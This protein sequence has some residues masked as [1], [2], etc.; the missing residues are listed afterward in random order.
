MNR[1]GEAAV[2]VLLVSLAALATVLVAQ[3]GF[4]LLPC[5]LCTYQRVPYLVAIP[6]A[7]A[8]LALH[9]RPRLAACLVGL[10]ALAF[11]IDSGIALFHVGVEQH[12]WQGLAS[13]SSNGAS[14]A[15]SVDDMLA[16]LSKPVKVP[17]CDQV[18]WALFGVSLA[19][20]NLLT[21]VGLAAFA[22][23]AARRGWRQ[24]R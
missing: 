17:A 8:A 11:L 4:G 19:G 18:P 6:L 24:G 1:T 9:G 10:C 16:A 3:Y 5:P 23:A 15:A 13:C 2:V 14:A 22:A 20:Y 21:C 7:L 12:W